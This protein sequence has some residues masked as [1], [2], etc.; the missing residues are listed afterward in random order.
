[1][2]SLCITLQEWL[3]MN[4]CLTLSPEQTSSLEKERLE[5]CLHLPV[6]WLSTDT[7]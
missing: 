5:P 1:M 2:W 7:S 3:D 6:A 4:C